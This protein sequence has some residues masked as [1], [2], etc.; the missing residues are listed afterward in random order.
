MKTIQRRRAS[1]RWVKTRQFSYYDLREEISTLNE[2]LNDFKLL[3]NVEY[4]NIALAKYNNEKEKKF[5][6]IIGKRSKNHK[7]FSLNVYLLDGDYDK[8][9]APNVNLYNAKEIGQ[10]LIHYS[11][12]EFNSRLMQNKKVQR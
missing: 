10:S 2:F 3:H 7:R 12:N 6:E 8:I 4:I 1:Q 9:D 11:E 5:L